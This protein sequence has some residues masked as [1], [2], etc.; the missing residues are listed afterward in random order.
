MEL[1]VPIMGLSESQKSS[2]SNIHHARGGGY[3][4]ILQ[5]MGW[6]DPT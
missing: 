5:S 4:V 1:L 3:F 2:L 6:R